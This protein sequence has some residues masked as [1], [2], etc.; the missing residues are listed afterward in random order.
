[1]KMIINGV[2]WSNDDND[3]GINGNDNDSNDVKVIMA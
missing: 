3:E 2:I 1:M